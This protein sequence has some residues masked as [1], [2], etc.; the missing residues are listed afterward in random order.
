MATH[1][2]ILAWEI[3]WTGKPGGLQSKGLQRVGHDWVTKPPRITHTHT[4]THT[5]TCNACIHMYS[6]TVA[7]VYPRPGALKADAEIVWFE[8]CL[9]GIHTCERK[10]ET[11]FF[12]GQGKSGMQTSFHPEEHSRVSV[13]SQSALASVR[14]NWCTGALIPLGLSVFRWVLSQGRYDLS[15]G[16]TITE[17]GPEDADSWKQLSVFPITEQWVLPLKRELDG[18]SS[19]VPYESGRIGESQGNETP[20][21]DAIMDDTRIVHLSKHIDGT[22]PSV[23]PG[24]NCGLWLAAMN[25]CRFIKC[26]ECTALAGRLCVCGAGHVWGIFVIFLFILLWSWNYSLKSL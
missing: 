11:I 16:H 24:K 1:S 7:E 4:H 26:N 6:F 20:L 14:K 13:A 23:S 3:P 12:R 5:H 18:A 10:E 8:R 9:S 19:Y 21:S 15:G 2:S 17:A 25:Q 22:A